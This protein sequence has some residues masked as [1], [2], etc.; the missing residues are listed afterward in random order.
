MNES[1][2][3]RFS[4]TD[5]LNDIKPPADSVYTF[6]DNCES[7]E[8]ELKFKIKNIISPKDGSTNQSPDKSSP[9]ERE[10]D[11]LSNTVPAPNP[12]IRPPN[13]IDEETSCSKS[14]KQHVLPVKVKRVP[15]GSM[16]PTGKPA[17]YAMEK[18]TT[19]VR[20]KPKRKALVAMYQSQITDN[21]IGIKLKL[22]KSEVLTVLPAPKSKKVAKS[23]RKRSRKSKPKNTSDSDDS[24]YEK[25]PRRVNNNKATTVEKEPE[26]QS[27]WGLMI[28]EPILLKIF[29]NV[30][31]QEG[32][33]PAL[34]RLGKVCSQWN[35]VS[36][37][38][39][40]W[41]S[42]DFSA[43]TKE[44]WRTELNLKWLIENRMQSCKD[45][46]IANWKV[47]NI[48]CVLSIL[49][50]SCPDLVGL[51]LAGWKGFASEHLIFIVEQFKSLQRLDL[52]SI[53]IEMTNKSTVSLQSL[54]HSIQTMGEKLTHLYLAHNKLAGVP[55][56]VTALSTYC[57]N[58][59][60]L[61]LSNVSTIAA[62]HGFLHIEKLQQG[63]QKLKVLRI[64]NSHITLSPAT[65]QEQMDSPG[66]PELEE[67]SIASLAD[68]SRLINDDFI[69]R[70]LKTSTKLQLLDVRGCARLTHDSL[71]RLPT[72][73]LKHLFLSG[74]SVTRDTGGGLELIAS[75]WAHSLTEFDLAWANVQTPLDNAI[76]AIAEKGSESPL[77]H[78][79]LCG[80]SVSLE[81]VK[82]ILTNCV[83]LNSINL[84]SCRGLPRGF[85]RLL[86]GTTEIKELR[87][88]LGVTLKV[89]KSS[90]S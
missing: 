70:I 17:A 9:T 40:L 31:N 7:D 43:W 39:R 78:L 68:E 6:S 88:N 55:Q 10:T 20:A 90:D 33:L 53:N 24:S 77:H 86:Q 26:E 15:N 62:S 28:P 64:T 84:S 85:K 14:P 76:R 8:G 63:C 42:L 47:T 21:K 52:S 75:K 49:A 60:L 58:L 12:D 41:H 80:S 87:D 18:K 32:C 59:T 74:C 66:F 82:E 25:K 22:K 2:E 51:S 11:N 56:I 3:S 37:T 4:E 44:K 79:N 5:T 45:L 46:N 71:I 67:L 36:V 81:A 38:P 13:R 48:D 73:D 89:P 50:N 54:C 1:S 19:K 30:V 72:W 23:N 57:P 69:Q 16:H 65:L 34:V 35:Q 83:D 27:P 61:D 29:E